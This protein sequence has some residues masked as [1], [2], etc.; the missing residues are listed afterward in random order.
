[1]TPGIEK[2]TLCVKNRQ[3]S[4]CCVPEKSL[5]RHATE[6]QM[7]EWLPT[8]RLGMKAVNCWRVTEEITFKWGFEG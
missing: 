7:R 6:T 5:V 1:M 2:P 3:D 8:F 4:E